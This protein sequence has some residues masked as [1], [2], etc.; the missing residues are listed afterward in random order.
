MPTDDGRAIIACADQLL[1][2]EGVEVEREVLEEVA[3]VRVIAVAED[4][5]APEV[6]FVMLEFVGDVAELRIELVLL[7][8]LRAGERA[9]A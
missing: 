5:L 4:D 6:L 9:V 2:A 8:R 1:E 7:G 3:L